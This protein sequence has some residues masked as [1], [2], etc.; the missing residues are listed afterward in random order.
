MMQGCDVVN[1][2]RHV[3]ADNIGALALTRDGRG[4]WCGSL[5]RA[6][7]A[8]RMAGVLNNGAN[9]TVS[10][11]CLATVVWALAHPKRGCLFPD[12]LAPDDA[13]DILRR[14]E[15]Y[16]GTVVSCAVPKHVLPPLDQPFVLVATATFPPIVDPYAHQ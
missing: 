7:D 15:P 3:S 10:A 6:T 9:V 11:A 13:E 12:D 8:Q 1:T 4:W 5:C 2:E 16:L 14:C